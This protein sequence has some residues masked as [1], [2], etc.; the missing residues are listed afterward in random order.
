MGLRTG[1]AGGL[2]LLLLRLHR[3]KLARRGQRL[4]GGQHL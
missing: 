1:L 4:D 2:V 3:Q